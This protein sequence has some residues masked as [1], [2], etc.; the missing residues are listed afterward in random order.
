M[1]ACRLQNVITF[2]PDG[3]FLVDSEIRMDPGAGVWG[4]QRVQ[5]QFTSAELRLARGQAMRLP[6]FGKGW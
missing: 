2:P 1:P 6:P 4:G 5:F 3:L